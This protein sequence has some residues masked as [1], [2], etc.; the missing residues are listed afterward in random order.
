MTAL[1]PP[2]NATHFDTRLHELPVDDS[3]AATFTRGTVVAL[4]AEPAGLE[5]LASE[6]PALAPRMR[7]V[8][9][10]I[11]RDIDAADDVVQNA[12]VKAIRG[13]PRFDGRARLSTWLHRIVV[14]EALM[15]LRSESRRRR[16]FELEADTGR[17]TD[18]YPD[19]DAD[20]AG[21]LIERERNARLKAGL[22]ALPAPERDVLEHCA[23][24]GQSYD[25]YGA[26]RGIGAAAAKSRAFRARRHLRS[27][28][29]HD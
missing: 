8:A 1:A 26:Q 19:S 13:L 5:R 25:E 23:L 14:N 24:A 10:G 9:R 20:P 4:Q 2:T 28:L 22:A 12:F 27:W 11:V 18:L 16:R 29:Q 6:L 17:N 7:S 3:R 21:P 15:W